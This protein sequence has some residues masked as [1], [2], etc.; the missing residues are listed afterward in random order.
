MT[1]KSSSKNTHLM[2]ILALFLTLAA[3][4]NSKKTQCLELNWRTEGETR[5]LDGLT[6]KS[7]F[8][9]VCKG[10]YSEQELENFEEGFAR[11]LALL[12]TTQKGFDYGRDGKTYQK[13]CPHFREPDFLKGYYKGRILFLEKTLDENEELYRSSEERVWRKER[14]YTIMRN[15]DPE[16]AKLEA[17]VLESFREEARSLAL[18]TVELKRELL[19][20]KRLSAESFF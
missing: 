8:L 12:C 11:G 7:D 6:K 10:T 15:Q 17:D 18:R 14:E 3:C 19:K 1:V 2:L 4:Q 20:T 13:T 16:R 9:K 5:A